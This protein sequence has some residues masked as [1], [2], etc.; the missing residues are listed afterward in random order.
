MKK[1]ALYIVVPCYNEQEVLPITHEHLMSLLQRLMAAG[2]VSDQSR[3][4]YVDDGSA[5]ATWDM[6]EEYASDEH[7]CAIRL[8][9][10]V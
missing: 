10:N 5:D 1:C 9:A 3:V 2:M 4:A 6:L 8:S 7:V